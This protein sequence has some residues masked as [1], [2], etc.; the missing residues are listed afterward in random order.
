LASF[1]P[2][3]SNQAA[4][5]EQTVTR[6]LQVLQQPGP[7]DGPA[8]EELLPL[9]YDELRRIARRCMAGEAAGQTLQPTALVHEA[10]LRLLGPGGDELPWNSRGHFFAAAAHAMRRI[11]VERA[12]R[13]R[14]EKHGGGRARVS[15]ADADPAS[16]A[17]EP[18]PDVMVALDIALS[19]LERSEPRKARVVMLRYFAGLTI[20][21]TAQAMKLSVTTV[22]QEWQF[23]RAWLQSEIDRPSRR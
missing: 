12:R 21:Q 7:S 19:R 11:L 14:S 4:G 3:T 17:A 8:T 2:G 13:N 15:L 1:P 18:E 5:V 16:G 10:Y 20:E 9:V 23:A 6:I 22:K